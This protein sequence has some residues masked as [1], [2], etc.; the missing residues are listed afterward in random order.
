M[1][2][3]QLLLGDLAFIFFS[4]V[5]AFN[6]LWAGLMKG[7]VVG[8]FVGN[9]EVNDPVHKVKA[10]ET[11][12]EDHTR[13][14]VNAWW[15]SSEHLVE[16]LALAHQCQ[17]FIT[18]YGRYH[19]SRFIGALENEN[20]THKF[21]FKFRVMD[22]RLM[23]LPWLSFTVMCL[24]LGREIKMQRIVYIC[25]VRSDFDQSNRT[26]QSVARKCRILLERST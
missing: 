20:K 9:V 24:R 8:Y 25:L 12:W 3:D 2:R 1:K 6:Q 16:I 13:V 4:S 17:L 21:H 19:C 5:V 11:N 23:L 22:N 26:N 14:F 18:H 7:E 10:S 15:R